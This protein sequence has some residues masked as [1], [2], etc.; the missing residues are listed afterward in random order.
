MSDNIVKISKENASTTNNGIFQGWGTSLCWWAHRVGY[1]P[2]LTEN[3]ARLFFGD[4][5]LD[6]NIMR[7]NIG[8]GDDPAHNHIKRTDSM[9]PGWLRY[10]KDT[11][12]FVYDYN[13]D[14]NQLNVLKACYDVGVA[15]QDGRQFH[16]PCH[17]RM[18]LASPLSRIQEAFHRLDKYVFNA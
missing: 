9:I 8:G 2:V 13:A 3:A 17:I 15:V 11:D 6:L 7:Y 16:G 10:D 18:N 12:S 5:G 4:E 1:S 14:S